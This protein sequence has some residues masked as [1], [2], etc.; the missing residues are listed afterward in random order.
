MTCDT[1]DF[2]QEHLHR[3]N[4]F[5]THDW[6]FIFLASIAASFSANERDM[7]IIPF[8]TNRKKD[9]RLTGTGHLYPA[10]W[11]CIAR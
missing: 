6:C 9:I 10:F 8:P 5:N 2:R 3:G 1:T 11:T 4:L 7:T